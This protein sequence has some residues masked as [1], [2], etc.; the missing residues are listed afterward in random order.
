MNC[1]FPER[2][3]L[4]VKK[5]VAQFFTRHAN[6]ASSSR[7][8]GYLNEDFFKESEVARA[9]RNINYAEVLSQPSQKDC[10]KTNGELRRNSCQAFSFFTLGSTTTASS[11]EKLQKFPELCANKDG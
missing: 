5:F 8:A 7:R 10:E 9:L 3:H 6:R 1:F 2:K 11:E 4:F